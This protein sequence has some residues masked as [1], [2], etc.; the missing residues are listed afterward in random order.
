MG[1]SRPLPTAAPRSMAAQI[2]QMSSK[3]PQL[4]VR[5]RRN[6]AIWQG[7]WCPSDLS[8]TYFVRITYAF[9]SRPVIAVL[10]P[11]LKLAKGKCRL[12]HVYGDGQL[13]I[14]VHEA[15][16]WNSRL[17]IADTIMP[18]VSQWLRFYEYWEQTGS[19]EGKGTHPEFRSHQSITLG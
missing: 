15:E 3:H 10:S 9:R 17:F 11:T 5:L 4:K 6:T 1:K 13:D 19:W 18:W 12:P 14:C 16:E 2:F 7:D 8:D